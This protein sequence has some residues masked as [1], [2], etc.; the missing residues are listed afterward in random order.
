M[1]K[2]L[3]TGA[4]GQLGRAVVEALVGRGIGVKAAT[5]STQKITWTDWVQPVALDYENATLHKAAL[6]GVSGLFLIA[7][8]LDFDAPA[9]LMPF[10]DMAREM[11]IKHIVFNSALGVDANEQAPLRIIERYLQR[12][13]PAYTILRP[14]FFMENFSTGFSAPMIMNGEITL[15]AG[16]GKTS[17][18]SV[19]DI[20][21]VTG[22]VFQ[23]KH[24]G[25][26]YNLT[27]PERLSYAQV[28][29]IISATSGRKVTY[30]P[31]SEAE[32]VERA[33]AGGIPESAVR[34]LAHLY[35]AVRNGLM[36]AVTD[37]VRTVTGRDPIRFSEFV[38]SNVKLWKLSEAA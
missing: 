12:T 11:G 14:N 38:Q 31:V 3:V 18:I 13:V 2:I 36:A 28:A 16:E 6:D 22:V 24:Y 5:R 20:A 9:K 27:G 10:I 7:A 26:E 29:D 17:F 4:S 32:M 30:H 33:L 21:E 19:R 35:S 8:P 25:V 23:D 1:D 15:A 37:D 34:Y